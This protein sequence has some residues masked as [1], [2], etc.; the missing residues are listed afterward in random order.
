MAV[1]AEQAASVALKIYSICSAARSAALAA[2][3]R[4]EA[5]SPRKGRDLQ[6]AI[7]I[8]FEE[9]AFGTNKKIEL[10]KYVQCPT[11]KGEG[12][13]PGTTK[14]TCPK[15]GGS[16]QISQAQRTPFGQF[17]SGYQPATG[18]AAAGKIIEDTLPG[19]QRTGKG[20]EECYDFG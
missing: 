2:D 3:S 8:T 18:A 5:I 1:S 12:A 6:K 15:C 16:G 13:K 20:Q 9:A 11:C 7:T 4:E 10:S 17:Q 14:K 19:L